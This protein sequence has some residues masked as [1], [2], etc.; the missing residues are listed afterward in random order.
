MPLLYFAN[1]ITLNSIGD[2]FFLHFGILLANWVGDLWWVLDYGFICDCLGKGACDAPRRGM[3]R[4]A[5]YWAN[6]M[7]CTGALHAP[8]IYAIT[9]QSQPLNRLQ[10]QTPSNH[11]QQ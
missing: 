9:D 2:D 1:L 8:P 3:D 10:H 7:P 6:L 5:D 4:W 11:P